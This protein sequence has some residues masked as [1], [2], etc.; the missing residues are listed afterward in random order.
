MPPIKKFPRATAYTKGFTLV[1]LSIVLVII[2]LLVGGVL[3]GRDL[4]KAAE[5]R[6]QIKQIE[7]FKT[8][9]NAFRLKYGYLPGDI[10]PAQASQFGF[11]TF[12]GSYAGKPY[13]F[14]YAPFGYKRYGFGNGSG[15]IETGEDYVFWQHLSEANMIAGTFGGGVNAP[16]YLKADTTAPLTGGQPVNP[17]A[18]I[19]AKDLFLPNAKLT[20]TDRHILV[21]A[22]RVYTNFQFPIN[23][24]FA[25]SFSFGATPNQ[26]F[27]IDS[28]ID[29]GVAGKGAVRDYVTVFVGLGNPPCVITSQPASYDLKPST[30]DTP[31]QCY[32]TILW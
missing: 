31:D 9:A 8:A 24:P 12:T 27:A 11:F 25:N 26:S 4:I 3:V 10:P 20:S 29:D 14:T 13:L 28:K 23:T 2:G 16:N 32:I 22:I 1:E 19:N 15:D 30:A 21:S 18:N 7:E 6:S 5:I 17:I